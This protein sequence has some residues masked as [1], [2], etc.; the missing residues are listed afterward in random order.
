MCLSKKIVVTCTDSY[1]EMIRC[2]PMK[3]PHKGKINCACSFVHVNLHAQKHA[4]NYMHNSPLPYLINPPYQIASPKVNY[5]PMDWSSGKIYLPPLTNASVT[6]ESPSSRRRPLEI[7]HRTKS[8]SI[9]FLCYL[10]TKSALPK[11]ILVRFGLG[12]C[13][14]ISTVPDERTGHLRIAVVASWTPRN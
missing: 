13:Q 14:N 12:K 1:V 4:Q 3:F 10:Q 9:L 5:C 8:T 6:C 2:D 11:S 7:N